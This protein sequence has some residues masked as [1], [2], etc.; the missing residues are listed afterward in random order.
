MRNRRGRC[1]S[2]LSSNQAVAPGRLERKRG[3]RNRP[4][5]TSAMSRPTGKISTNTIGRRY[6][7][8]A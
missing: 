7:G 6:S 1:E 5:L 3:L 2:A 4:A 8:L